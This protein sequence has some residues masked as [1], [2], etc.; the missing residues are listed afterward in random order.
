MSENASKTAP[1]FN[2][3]VMH[4]I[5]D[6]V[7]HCL[8]YGL[9]TLG[10]AAHIQLAKI[11]NSCI[12]II[13]GGQLISS[14]DAI[15]DDAILF[16]FEQLGSNS[17]WVN[18]AYLE[19]MRRRVVWDYSSQNIKWLRQHGI[20]HDAR[21]IGLGYAPALTRIP[22]VTTQDIDVLF[23]GA[24]SE[25]RRLILETLMARGLNVAALQNHFGTELDSHIARAKVVLN[26]HY[27]DGS[28]IF[29]IVRALPLFANRKAIVSEVAPQTE[30]APDLRDA[31]VGV[32]YEQ[33]VDAC[34]ALVADEQRRHALE[35]ECFKIFSSRNQAA[36]LRDGVAALAQASTSAPLPTRINLG[37]G[38]SY[39][40][41]ALNI[42]I[43]G[44][45]RPDITADI[46]DV[47][48]LE[49]RHETSRFGVCA[50]PRG[51]FT[52]IIAHQLLEHIP[53][54]DLA[55]RNILDIL[56]EGGILDVVVP[57]DLSFGAWQDPT[58]VRA[59]NE[60]SWL[61]YTSWFWYMGWTEAR[62]DILS[63]EAVYSDYGRR[64]LANGM[65]VEDVTR[66]PRAVDEIKVLLRK[67]RLTEAEKLKTLE[68][69]KRDGCVGETSI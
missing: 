6:D 15:E 52:H 41:D 67:R 22:T 25:R 50:L 26:L 23:F 40:T 34:C 62:F 35:E 30:I 2:I 33:L 5:F 28:Q 69:L 51:Y 4:T 42:D 14:W 7:A 49:Q 47:D 27:Y 48:L 10:Y 39:M 3:C 17:R 1:I 46:S 43:N 37:S 44:Y 12:N 57:Y 45:W 19:Q 63:I 24:V 38:K 36:L 54:L 13:L 21:L 58:H 32:P 9:S 60:Q 61:Y 11:Q 8:Q 18:D 16:N 56:A 29:E 20:N 59:F 65:P 64:L 53:R 68:Y 31:I 55:M 66:M